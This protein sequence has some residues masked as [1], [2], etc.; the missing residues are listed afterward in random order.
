MGGAEH[1]WSRNLDGMAIYFASRIF[2]SEECRMPIVQSFRVILFTRVPAGIE[3]KSAS[4]NTGSFRFQLPHSVHSTPVPGN[5]PKTS[6]L[7][8]FISVNDATP[9][10]MP[11]QS[12]KL[13]E[14]CLC[15]VRGKDSFCWILTLSQTVSGDSQV[16]HRVRL[17]IGSAPCYRSLVRHH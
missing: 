3:S 12:C 6:A 13:V 9:P 2:A 8:L 4:G 5:A 14:P 11:L 7:S 17:P 15:S 16:T 10:R 1:D